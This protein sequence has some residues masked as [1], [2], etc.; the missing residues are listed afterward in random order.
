MAVIAPQTD[1]YL[2]KVP[3]EIDEINQLTF[4]NA[5]AQYNYFNSLPK[6]GFD[7][8][9]YQ[10]KDGTLRIPALIDD[11]ISYNYVMYRNTAYSNKWFYAFITGMEYLNDSVTAVSIKTDV[12]QTWEFDLT[13]KPVLIDREHTNDDTVGANTLPEGLELGDF[14]TNGNVTNFGPTID[15]VGD[16]VIVIDVTQIENKG[17]TQTL[18]YHWIGDTDRT[19]AQ[20]VNGVPSG[21]FHIIL[22]YNS[23]I[24]LSA[25]SVLDVYENAGLLDA[26]QS[27]YI[28]PTEL[29]GE[30]EYGLELASINPEHTLSP[31][32]TVGGLGMPKNSVTVANLSQ[33]PATYTTPTTINGY[34]PKN[35]KLKCW[36]FQYLNVSN[37]VGTTVPF[38]YEDFSNGAKFRIEGVLC[39][40]GSTKAVP[41][42]YKGISNTENGYDYSINGP[43]YPLCSWNSDSYTNWLTQNGVNM[44][45]EWQK[46]AISGVA[47]IVGGAVGGFMTGGPV[48]ALVGGGAGLAAATTGTLSTAREQHLA[49]TH[50]NLTADQV[51]GNVNSSDIVWSK[52]RSM[53][54]FLPMSIKAEYARCIDEYFSQYGYKSNRVKVPNITGRRNWNYVKT[55]GCYIDADIPQDDLQE[56]K[57]M[58]DKGITF[59]HNPATFGDYSQNNDII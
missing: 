33:N 58:F 21:L 34:T 7:K 16:W 30:V 29:V 32:V 43:K 40:S 13:F 54:T 14:V 15:G 48:G 20:Y 35:N 4:S 11:I 59:W 27:V 55:V 2:L 1:V 42:D 36:P 9:T 6:L 52:W 41:V 44:R 31:P 19:P 28:V 51:E 5:T 3:L 25:R 17:N 56:I 26:V 47:S 39:P 57:S 37:N 38:R 12:W 46:N 8:F 22:G 23:S 49:K 45:M 53:F 24:V 50:A 18:G 10:R